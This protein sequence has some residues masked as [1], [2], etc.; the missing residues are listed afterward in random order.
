MYGRVA[1][2]NA[3][4]LQIAPPSDRLPFVAQRIEEHYDDEKEMDNDDNN[5][6]SRARMIDLGEVDEVLFDVL[7]KYHW[8]RNHRVKKL[9]TSQVA[10]LDGL[11]AGIWIRKF[12]SIAVDA[13]WGQRT[14][15]MGPLINTLAKGMLFEKVAEI[16]PGVRQ[17]A[18]EVTMKLLEMDK[19]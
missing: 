7:T 2:E 4:P 3:G 6:A 10:E 9:Q 1:P 5:K 19:V 15:G 16:I 17:S 8:K 13:N 14:I 12:G 11:K 18:V